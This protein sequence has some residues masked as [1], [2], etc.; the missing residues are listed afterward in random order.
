MNIKM[1]ENACEI[2]CKSRLKYGVGMWCD[3]MGWKITDR[4]PGRFY[5]K[6]LQGPQ[7]HSKQL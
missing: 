6:L 5:K 2:I 4:I 1:L 3:K 7:E